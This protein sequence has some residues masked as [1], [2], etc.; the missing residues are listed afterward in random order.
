MAIP[1]VNYITK[2][3]SWLRFATKNSPINVRYPPDFIALL[4]AL[5]SHKP[6]LVPLLILKYGNMK[7]SAKSQNWQIVSEI[8]LSY[9][10]KVKAADR[11]KITSSLSAYNIAMQLWN[12][13][14]MEYF[15][16]FKILLLNNSNK[17]LG[18]YEVSSGGITGTVVDI[19]IIFTAA[20][21]SNAT[22]IIMIHNHPSGT[23][24]ASQADKTITQKVKEAGKLLEISLLDHL[25]IT[26]ESYYSFADDG[27]L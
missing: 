2:F 13:N 1:S 22:G 8:E 24:I 10:S 20:L 16:E 23:L 7:N 19:R 27:A 6:V 12:P 17:V 26:S 9:K 18:A 3:G 14:T 15:E 5:A 11:P 4:F 21:K 25:I